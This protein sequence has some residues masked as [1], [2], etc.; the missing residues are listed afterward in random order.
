MPFE[1]CFDAVPFSLSIKIITHEKKVLQNS[2]LSNFK[3]QKAKSIKVNYYKLKIVFYDSGV[4]F[5]G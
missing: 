4:N 3:V 2:K 5:P 1:F